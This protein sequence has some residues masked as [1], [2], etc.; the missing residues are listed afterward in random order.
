MLTLES[1]TA[2]PTPVTLSKK[3]IRSIICDHFSD[4]HS[5]IIIINNHCA[6]ATSTQDAPGLKKITV[7]LNAYPA[8]R[9]MSPDPDGAVSVKSPSVV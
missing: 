7:V 3:A 9:T 1:F 5:W 8:T 6:H 4:N 2:F